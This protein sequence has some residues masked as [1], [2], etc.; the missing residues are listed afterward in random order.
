MKNEIIF[1][2][3]WSLRHWDP[4]MGLIQIK[5]RLTVVLEFEAF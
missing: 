5:K 4:S 2:Q 1:I 3:L